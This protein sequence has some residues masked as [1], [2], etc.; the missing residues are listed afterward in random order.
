MGYQPTLAAS[1]DLVIVD[2]EAGQTD[3]AAELEYSKEPEQGIW[4]RWKPGAWL[5]VSLQVTAPDDPALR[6]GY[7]TSPD[8]APGSVYQVSIWGDGIDPNRLPDDD[9]PPRALA[10]LSVFALKKRPD[11]RP[12]FSD[13]NERTGGTYREHQL[14]TNTPV[15]VY[16]AVST[17]EP[18]ED[19]GFRFF[20]RTDGFTLASLNQSFLLQVPDLLPGTHYYEL[21]RFSDEFGNWEFLSREFTTLQ[22]RIRLEPTDLFI[23]DDSDDFSNGE[24]S[25][26]FALYTGDVRRDTLT[27]ANGNLETGKSVTPAPGGVITVGP[28]QVTAETLI[29]SLHVGG[30]EDDSGSAPAAG[31]DP[32]FGS[33]DLL[34]PV[35]PDEVVTHRPDSI[36]ASGSGD[37][38]FTLSYK[39]WIEYF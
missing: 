3:G 16:L 20:A 22:R 32:A 8:L 7:F 1:P 25:F 29:V 27:Y 33:K 2:I 21:V 11:R 12:F 28:E 18:R 14:A 15:N 19:D 10:E 9:I 26:H 5:R 13:E 34:V 31:D 38:S 37:F 36:R 17:E 23:V 30:T 39:Y 24:G 35:G 4:H 6:H